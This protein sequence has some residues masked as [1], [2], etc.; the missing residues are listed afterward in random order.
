MAQY[1]TPNLLYYRCIAI[2]GPVDGFEYTMIIGRR[3]ITEVINPSPPVSR[4]PIRYPTSASLRTKP[5]A[6][7]PSFSC[8][9]SSAIYLLVGYWIFCKHRECCFCFT[10]CKRGAS[11]WSSLPPLWFVSKV[12]K[13]S[14]PESSWLFSSSSNWVK[15]SLGARAAMVFICAVLKKSSPDSSW[16]FW[17]T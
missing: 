4:T 6:R 8:D 11:Y 3:V 16:S 13:K 7:S 5:W 17:I 12:L 10:V 9:A 1:S 14:S 15:S 2:E